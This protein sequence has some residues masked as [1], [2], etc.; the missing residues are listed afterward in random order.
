MNYGEVKTRGS[1]VIFSSVFTLVLYCS[2][3]SARRSG[4]FIPGETAL[5]VMLNVP[6]ILSGGFEEETNLLPMLL[7]YLVI[8]VPV[9]V[10]TE[11]LKKYTHMSTYKISA[12]TVYWNI[13]G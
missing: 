7:L 5:D 8:L 12:Y 3:R 2:N 6:Q 1:E 13:V 4:S 10:H 9:D 11:G